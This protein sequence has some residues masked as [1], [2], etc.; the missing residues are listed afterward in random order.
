[1]PDA[2]RGGLQVG[3][4]AVDDD[5]LTEQQRRELIERRF[6]DLQGRYLDLL[7]RVAALEAAP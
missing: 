2:Q 5:A 3:H 1:M 6:Q 7:A 4:G